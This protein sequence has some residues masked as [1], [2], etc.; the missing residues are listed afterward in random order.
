MIDKQ[1]KGFSTKNK[2]SHFICLRIEVSNDSPLKSQLSTN[3][4]E[5]NW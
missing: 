2:F 5:I 1:R 3:F 4:Y